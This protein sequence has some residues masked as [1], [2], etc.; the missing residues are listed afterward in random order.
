MPL[1]FYLRVGQ[2]ICIGLSAVEVGLG[3]I[4]PQNSGETH[5]YSKLQLSLV[6]AGFIC[7]IIARSKL[8]GCLGQNVNQASINEAISYVRMQSFA[9]VPTA[10]RFLIRVYVLKCDSKREYVDFEPNFFFLL[11]I[12]VLGNV[13][14]VVF[15]LHILSLVS[16]RVNAQETVPAPAANLPNARC[17][18]M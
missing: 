10:I 3:I 1:S 14:I 2:N 5:I 7:F 4:S 11:T 9:V 15:C 13:I 12:P 8:S 17:R 6:L 18:L 16:K